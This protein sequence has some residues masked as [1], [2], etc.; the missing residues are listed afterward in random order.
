MTEYYICREKLTYKKFSTD[1]NYQKIRDHRHY[2]G[3]CRVA[4]HSICNSKFNVPH[5]VSVVFH[6]G[7]TYVY[8]FIVKELAKEFE[9]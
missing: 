1:K 4:A 9:R 5:E 8:Q 3:K 6:N 2:T 7:S